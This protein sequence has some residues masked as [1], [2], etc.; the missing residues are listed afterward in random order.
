MTLFD[1]VAGLVLA[2]SALIG[3][4]RG[5]VRE[6]V[7]LFA[8]TFAA[9]AAVFLLPL[10]APFARHTVHPGW[11]A[12]AVAVAVVFLAAYVAL[13]I[14][15]ATVSA[16]LRRQSTLGA[17]DR[18]V[19]LLFGLGRGLLLLGVF[20]IMF[21]A[22]PSGF[23]PAWVSRSAL[24]PLRRRPPRAGRSWPPAGGQPGAGLVG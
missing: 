8:F 2:V 22:V 13:R 7:S 10:S 9:M 14:L 4:S 17:L 19:G 20:Y 1:V 11:A 24:Y 15:G 16:I 6:L 21:S 23:A 5:I 18:G 12:N 3:L